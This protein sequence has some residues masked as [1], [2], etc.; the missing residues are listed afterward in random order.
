ME[1]RFVLAGVALAAA[2]TL[3]GCSVYPGAAAVVDGRAISE[4]DLEEFI[5]SAEM[6]YGTPRAQALSALAQIQ[7]VQAPIVEKHAKEL[8]GDARA[9]AYSTCQIAVPVDEKS[10]APFRTW[11]EFTYLSQK[12]PEVIAEYEA[13]LQEATFQPSLRYGDSGTTDEVPFPPFIAVQE[14]G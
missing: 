13:A 7:G 12:N 5:E 1:K 8:E 6:P 2:A 11:C 4:S 3:S 14:R 10:P 9:E